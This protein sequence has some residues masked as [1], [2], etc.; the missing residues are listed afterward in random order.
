[1]S[2]NVHL[3]EDINLNLMYLLLVLLTIPGIYWLLNTGSASGMVYFSLFVIFVSV[4]Y[5]ITTQIKESDFGID[6]PIEKTS[7]QAVGRLLLGAAVMIGL[8]FVLRLVTLAQTVS[9]AF[10]PLNSFS[11]TSKSTTAQSF[12]SLVISTD[13][14]WYVWMKD[15]TAPILEELI[16]GFGFVVFGFFLT[17]IIFKLLGVNLGHGEDTALFIGS[18]FFSGLFF[19]ALHL[20]NNTYAGNT[21]QLIAAFIFRIILNVMIYTLQFGLSFSTG[22][23]MANNFIDSFSQ[24]VLPGAFFTPWGAIIIIIFMIILFFFITNFKEVMRQLPLIG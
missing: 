16:T 19:M 6:V 4:I 5:Y 8:L 24:G 21:C 2:K 7:E 17:Y 9:L 22:V 10:S 1:M 18:I 13:P 11:I 15:I 12:A 14:G 20:F 23:H 3:G